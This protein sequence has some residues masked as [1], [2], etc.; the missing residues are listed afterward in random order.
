MADGININ[1]SFSLFLSCF[2]PAS[3]DSL[4]PSE[5]TS[6]YE[7]CIFFWLRLFQL[8]VCL[9]QIFVRTRREINDSV[10]GRRA[11]AT[12][13]KSRIAFHDSAG[14]RRPYKALHQQEIGGE[15]RREDF[16]CRHHPTTSQSKLARHY[17]KYSC[18]CW[19]FFVVLLL[20]VHLENQK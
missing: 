13:T 3:A 20:V 2:L 9:S 19:S 1:K 14:N 17:C 15:S 10:C 16:H 12:L 7:W 6:K 5:R 8:D 4:S 11:R 18:F